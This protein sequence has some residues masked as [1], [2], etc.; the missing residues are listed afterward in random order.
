MIKKNWTFSPYDE[1][2]YNKSKHRVMFFGADPNAE[3]EAVKTT[4]MGVWFRERLEKK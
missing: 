2:V 1:E 4:D 3:K